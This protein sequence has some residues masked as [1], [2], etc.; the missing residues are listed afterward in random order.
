M[1]LSLPESHGKN[2]SEEPGAPT[3]ATPKTKAQPYIMFQEKIACTATLSAD[4]PAFLLTRSQYLQSQYFL[5]Y[6]L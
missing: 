5:V 6:L 2:Y 1:F 4:V 3:G